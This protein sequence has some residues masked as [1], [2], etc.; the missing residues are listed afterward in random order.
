[1][2]S[3]DS[4]E[5]SRF[6][7]RLL[8]GA[9]AFA[10]FT[11]RINGVFILA[12]ATV[13]EF[14]PSPE[15]KGLRWPTW[16]A[17]LLPYLPFFLL[18]AIWRAVFPGG[19]EGYLQLLRAVTV[20]TLVTNALAYP[21]S[22]FDFFTSGHY[23][24]VTA[25]LLGPLVLWGAFTSW[26]RT[27][28]ISVY[29][30]LTLAMY[31]VWTYLQG[32]RFM[33]PITP[34]LVILMMFGLAAFAQWKT[35]GKLAPRLALLV[36]Y[37]IPILFLLV[38]SALVATGKLPQEKWTPY[39]QPSS[40]MFQWIR[41]NTSSDAVISFFKPR[42]M[43]LL[44]QRL[45][46]TPTLADVPKV[47]YFVYSKEHTWNEEHPSLQQYQQAAALTPAFENRNFIVFRVGP[48]P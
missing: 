17:L 39:D 31:I 26:R 33:L 37:G 7:S 25:I 11:F 29:G 12:A 36:Q 14:L 4:S 15:Q 32:Y 38:S 23:S 8:T 22:L 28:H 10:A 46:L 3:R 9:L 35:P 44:G 24:F 47:S 27:A 30:L 5:R 13:K 48:K 42:A 6:R 45:C 18:Y 19:G 1:M 2:E 41:S 16:K 34:F 43:H 40:E 20:H 21:V